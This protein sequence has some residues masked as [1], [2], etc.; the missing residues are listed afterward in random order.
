MFRDIA[1][2]VHIN[3][4]RQQLFYSLN[5]HVVIW[6]VNCLEN[7]INLQFCFIPILVCSTEDLRRQICYHTL[8]I[9]QTIYT[10]VLLY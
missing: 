10:I 8:R 2:F 1:L 9:I 7:Q 4:V 6:L 5:K 3:I